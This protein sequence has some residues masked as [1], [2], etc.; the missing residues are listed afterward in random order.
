M[1]T[2]YDSIYVKLTNRP[3]L[4]YGDKRLGQGVTWCESLG[5]QSSDHKGEQDPGVMEMFSILIMGQQGSLHLS[6]L[7]EHL[8]RLHY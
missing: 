1:D 4:I 3:Q 6:K 7:I 2:Y 5:R 8:K